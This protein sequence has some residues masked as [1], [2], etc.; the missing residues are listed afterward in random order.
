MSEN[1]ILLCM[2]TRPEIIKMAPIY[3]ALRDQGLFP[4][5]LHTGQHMEMA[6]PMYEFFGMVPDHNVELLRSSD[7]LAHLSALILDKLGEVFATL[8]PKAVLVHGDT[9]SA[10]MATLAAFYQQVPVGH[11]EAG[12]RSHNAYDPFPEE[13]NR[14]LIGRLAQWHFAPTAGASRNLLQEGVSP[15]RVEIVG[16]SIV[17][18]VRLGSDRLD[19]HNDLA[20][21]IQAG[22]EL[23]RLAQ[24]LTTAPRL[25]VVTAHRRENWDGPI[26]SIALAVRDLLETNADMTVVWPVH[27]N[28]KVGTTVRQ[29]FSELPQA[30]AHR[31]FLTPPISY[32]TMLWLLR[33]AWMVLTDSGGIQEEAACLHVPILVLRETTERPELIECGG[34]ALIGTQRETIVRAV[35]RLRGSS[36]E[37]AAMQKAR[38]PFGDGTTAQQICSTLSRKQITP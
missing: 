3:H 30:V 5:L 24:V 37:Y 29:V 13:K 22:G 1:P 25:V 32:P 11:V 36:Q 35:T 28:P 26:S 21:E 6:Q 31:L 34:G 27:L 4:Q 10:V 15:S 38:N 2:G 8:N 20:E 9:T 33:R 14:E 12:L 23:D 17:D 19:T 18:A 16:N 7:R